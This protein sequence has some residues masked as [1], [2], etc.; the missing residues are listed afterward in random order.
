MLLTLR[1]YTCSSISLS[2]CD[3]TKVYYK[4]SMFL[5][6]RA[7]TCSSISLSLCDGTYTY[8]NIPRYHQR[9]REMEEQVEALNVS[10]IE[11]L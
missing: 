1:A 2:L 4:S 6:L 7:S 5:T 3:G 10:N 8:Y 9:D 11:D